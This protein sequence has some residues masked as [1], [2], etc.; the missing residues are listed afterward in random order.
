MQEPRCLSNT[1][2]RL[3]SR[4]Y[5][6]SP[7][8]HSHS[9]VHSPDRR[10]RVER[11]SAHF[12]FPSLAIAKAEDRCRLGAYVTRV[13]GGHSAYKSAR[14]APRSTRVRG[15]SPPGTW[16]YHPLSDEISLI[17]NSRLG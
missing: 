1:K 9:G 15:K 11:E 12:N 17:V 13:T 16:P 2:T 7:K 10:S 8:G 14:T 4:R 5:Y 3:N 6:S